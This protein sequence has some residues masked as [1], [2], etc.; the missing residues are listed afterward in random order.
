MVLLC[1]VVAG[2]VSSNIM[3]VT[4][5]LHGFSQDMNTRLRG[6]EGEHVSVSAR[7]SFG[8]TI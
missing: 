6:N 3:V 4:A 2:T 5:G 1:T 7:R 8:L